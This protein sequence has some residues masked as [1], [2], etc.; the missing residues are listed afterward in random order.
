MSTQLELPSATDLSAGPA[1]EPAG[2]RT[3]S[4]RV[5]KPPVRYEPVEQVED[6]YASDEYDDAESDV[7]SHVEFSESELEDE[8]ADSD[9]DDFIVEDKSE[10]DEEDNNGSE[11]DSDSGGGVP[12]PV[13]RA[14]APAA[15]AKVPGRRAVTKKK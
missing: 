10:S 6:D 9:L 7:S 8:E 11:S 1:P 14:P 3:R 4:G 15:P 13:A 2:L 5:S 12:A